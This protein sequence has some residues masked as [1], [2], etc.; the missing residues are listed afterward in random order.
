MRRDTFCLWA[1]IVECTSTPTASS[2]ECRHCQ[3]RYRSSGTCALRP[4]Q[5]RAIGRRNM[6]TEPA[7]LCTLNDV[8]LAALACRQPLTRVIRTMLDAVS[9]I[10]SR[11]RPT[12][13][14][15]VR[16]SREYC[17][18]T[19]AGDL[20][21]SEQ[22]VMADDLSGDN[23]GLLIAT[24][25]LAKS[26]IVRPRLA[27]SP[28]PSSRFPSPP[29]SFQPLAWPPFAPPPHFPSTYTHRRPRQHNRSA[30]GRHLPLL[31]LLLL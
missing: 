21:G 31:S 15:G 30:L 29:V 14:T 9:A 28:L 8:W 13:R 12:D 25:Y 24:D 5:C 4:P 20:S 27:F 3:P 18:R 26:L 22:H 16:P 1:R 2:S 6:P 19:R 23:A 10:E 17:A 11:N 7:A